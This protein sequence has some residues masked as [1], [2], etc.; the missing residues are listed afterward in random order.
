MPPRLCRCTWLQIAFVECQMSDELL[1]PD[2]MLCLC[3]DDRALLKRAL[4]GF[5][6]LGD[7]DKEELLNFYAVHGM[8]V[9]FQVP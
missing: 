8:Q 3:L 5:N 1:L 4:V 2:F 7:R 9:R 6:D